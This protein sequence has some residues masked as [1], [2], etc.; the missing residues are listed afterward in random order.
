MPIPIPMPI[1]RCS[2]VL[3][4]F[5]LGSCEPPTSKSPLSDPATAKADPGL[6]GVFRGVVGDAPAMLH[7]VPSRGPLVDV[8]VVGVDDDKGAVVL[9]YEAFPTRLGDKTYLNL[10]AKRFR[11]AYA[12]EVEL[13]D[14]YIFV[15]YALAP[16]GTLGLWAMN[17]EPAE[18][19]VGKGALAGTIVD[20]QVRL[21]GDSAAVAAFV[22]GA[23][24]AALFRPFGRFKKAGPLPSA[25]SVPTPLAP[26]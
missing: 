6:S 16:D 3:A 2:L 17:P 15:R 19:S 9:H 10:R 20:G 1:R 5:A 13:A 14:E 22:R 23:E 18:A 8:V 21:T 25:R 11:G 4:L 26:H 7:F 12:T 24:D